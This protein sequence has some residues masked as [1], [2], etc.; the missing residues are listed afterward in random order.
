MNRTLRPV[1]GTLFVFLA[2]ATHLVATSE[3]ARPP[4]AAT[5]EVFSGEGPWMVRAYYGEESQ[6]S[7]L[8]GWTDHFSWNRESGFV[9][10]QA[11]VFLL[12]RLQ[13]AGYRLQLDELATADIVRAKTAVPEGAGIPGF[14]CYR[15]VEE[16][17]T[18][19]AALVAQFP[20][21][22]SW[23]D[24]GDSWE[25]T[26]NVA[27]GFDLQVLR[28]TNSAIAGPKPT[29]FVNAAMHAREYATAELAT[30][31]AEFLLNGYGQDADATWLVDHHEI[32]LLLQTNPD[33]RKRAETGLSW[34]K[35]T[36]NNFCANTTLRGIDLN[37]NF[38]FQWGC[39]GG[40]SGNQCSEIF[41]GPSAAS[42][43]EVQAV[44]S[45]V[46]SIFPDQRD[47]DPTAA[48]P[49]DATGVY[50]DLHSFGE[51]VVWP[52]LFDGSVP[53][54]GAAIQTLGRK[55]AFF[56]GYLPLQGGFGTADGIAQDFAYGDLGVASY[57]I[58]LGT[59]FFQDCTTF[60][61]TILPDNLLALVYAAKV[62]RTP[63]LT[64]QGPEAF[65]LTLPAGP[66]ATSD[67]PLLTATVDDGRF[68]T[69]SGTEP[70][71]LIAAAELYVDLPPWSAGATATAMQAS[72]GVFDTLSEGVEVAVDLSALS[73]GRHTLFV[74]GQDTD[75]NW[76]AVSATF[77]EV[78]GS[79]IFAD[80]F[81]SGGTASWSSVVP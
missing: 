42:E 40:S 72:D 67:L 32:H 62:A 68:S 3:S 11:D 50:L 53:A 23:S 71:Q 14:P 55:Y 79:E 15:T 30:R 74:R 2:A 78:G 54:N 73:P 70:S 17:Y 69:A 28:I 29:L 44:Q 52:W 51:F 58:E 36:N 31:F 34:R 25:K 18:S 10:L 81:E 76:G 48:A 19:A 8:A 80:G 26:Q 16:T 24:I 9:T 12:D 56:T 1:L 66:F 33:G 49:A 41:H 7:E 57:T 39:C 47:P 77:I 21:L 20:T 6:L 22:A 4:V 46:R 63:Y 59:S 38:D 43:P 45:Y 75:G 27:N 35:N 65:A 60:E 61:N 5:G 64:P 37:R 13:Q